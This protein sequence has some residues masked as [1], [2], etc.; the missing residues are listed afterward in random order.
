MILPCYSVSEIVVADFVV[1]VVIIIFIV[2]NITC[3]L[4][5]RKNVTLF[6]FI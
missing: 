6:I 4:W 3:T 2:M 5:L 1:V